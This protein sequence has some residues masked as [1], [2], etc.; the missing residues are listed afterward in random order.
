MKN[1][2]NWK[3]GRIGLVLLAVI[4]SLVNCS[5]TPD[6]PTTDAYSAAANSDLNLSDETLPEE[7]FGSSKQVAQQETQAQSFNDETTPVEA[8]KKAPMA[9]PA[10]PNE[11]LQDSLAPVEDTK[12][13]ESSAKR[14]K[15]HKTARATMPESVEEVAPTFDEPTAPNA[16]Q[17][18]GEKWD[19]QSWEEQ[20]F[21]ARAGVTKEDVLSGRV[22]FV[23]PG[24]D[25]N[26]QINEIKASN[27]HLRGVA[28][29]VPGDHFRSPAAGSQSFGEGSYTVQ[30]G[31]TLQ[32][33]SAK[34]YGTPQRWVELYFLNPQM[35]HYNQLAPGSELTYLDTTSHVATHA[36]VHENIEAAIDQKTSQDAAPKAPEAKPQ[37]VAAPS[38]QPIQAAPVATTTPD[39]PAATPA[40]P[41]K[42]PQPIA[43]PTMDT[44]PK[45]RVFSFTMVRWILILAL[46]GVG[47]WGAYTWTKTRMRKKQQGV[48]LSEEYPTYSDSNQSADQSLP[49]SFDD[50]NRNS[51]S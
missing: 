36:P 6:K 47:V 32:K 14:G 11:E 15:K 22:V 5:S 4:F 33:I 51:M 43:L 34:I 3:H 45:K 13:K 42:A 21:L 48:A 26:S 29:L 20:R 9:A 46:G 2:F 41:N 39:Y 18:T 27:P 10:A 8:E 25:F 1:A 28:K 37:D 23:K 35:Q 38:A 49:D 16:Q 24:D 40:D 30:R 50:D 19:P 17:A 44:K 7:E 31:D 12:N